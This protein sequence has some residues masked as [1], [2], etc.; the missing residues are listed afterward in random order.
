MR[1]LLTIIHEILKT[2]IPGLLEP[3]VIIKCFFDQIVHLTFKLEKLD[4]KLDWILQIF[5]IRYNFGTF[6]KN[7]R[8][9]FI[10]YV[11]QGRGS[12]IEH[13]IHHAQLLYL[14]LGKHVLA[15]A[16]LLGEGLG[17]LL[18]SLLEKDVENLAFRLLLK[19]VI[20][21]FFFLFNVYRNFLDVFRG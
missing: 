13:L 7:V 8:V 6:L 11:Y 1:R 5:L 17:L 10:N 4:R 18:N 2:Q 20:C 15:A 3:H 14:V 19:E 12:S 9:H 21:I 16:L